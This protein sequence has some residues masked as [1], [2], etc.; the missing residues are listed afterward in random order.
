[1]DNGHPIA[2]PSS[3]GDVVSFQIVSRAYWESGCANVQS[4][5]SL[6]VLRVTSYF[7]A[8]RVVNIAHNRVLQYQFRFMVE[9]KHKPITEGIYYSFTQF[10]N[11]TN[12][13]ALLPPI[14][15]G[16]SSKG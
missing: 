6:R 15:W 12:V 4:C 10:L 9:H 2:I 5:G 1:M 14:V 3:R 8:N 13:V 11:A 7:I 16:W